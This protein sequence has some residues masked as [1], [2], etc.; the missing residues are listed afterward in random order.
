MRLT[1]D[2]VSLVGTQ[3]VRASDVAGDLGVQEGLVERVASMTVSEVRD[4]IV[5][6]E[7]T[8]QDAAE[9]ERAGRRRTSILTMR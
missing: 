6:G 3:T 8:A 7:M 9:A 4:A 5:A 2:G 1:D